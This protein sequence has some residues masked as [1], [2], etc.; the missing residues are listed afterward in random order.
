M[1]FLAHGRSLCTAETLPT[2]EVF[3]GIAS[4]SAVVTA[5]SEERVGSGADRSEV[6]V[7][8][9]VM[10]MY[11]PPAAGNSYTS[12]DYKVPS[13]SPIGDSQSLVNALSSIRQ[14]T[15]LYLL[16]GRQSRHAKVD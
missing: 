10:F 1:R 2:S 11:D 8:K 7:S 15:S 4:P 13:E 16:Q 12:A 6:E 5:S 14:K 3:P 9:T